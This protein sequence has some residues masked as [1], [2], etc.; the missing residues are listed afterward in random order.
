[1]SRVNDPLIK[2]EIQ[3][4]EKKIEILEQSIKSNRSNSTDKN[5]D[6]Q[7]GTYRVI[8]EDSKYYVEFKHKDGWIRS[9]ASNFTLRG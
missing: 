5:E 1:M 3:E 6:K 9:E 7:I 8:K 2:M 4:L